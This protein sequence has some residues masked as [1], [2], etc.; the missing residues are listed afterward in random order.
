MGLGL[1]ES[2]QIMSKSIIAMS[3]VNI[4]LA[5]Y[6]GF[7]IPPEYHSQFA[8]PIKDYFLISFVGLCTGIML[9]YRN[10]KKG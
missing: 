3:L 2:L 5:M 9:Y 4:S 8:M 10:K 1:V 7:F 6:V